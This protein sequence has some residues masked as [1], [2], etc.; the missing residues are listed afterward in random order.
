MTTPDAII[1]PIIHDP[2]TFPGSC[3]R[4]AVTDDGGVLCHY[5]IDEN[6]DI[7]RESA[8]GDGWH[9]IASDHF[10]N[11]DEPPECDHCHRTLGQQAY[12]RS[13]HNIADAMLTAARFV[14]APEEGLVSAM[15]WGMPAY[16]RALRDVTRFLGLLTLEHTYAMF[17]VMSREQIGHSLWLTRCHHGTGFWDMYDLPKDL[18]DALTNAAHAIGERWVYAT[19]ANKLDYTG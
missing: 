6:A 11:C 7:I 4:F 16:R 9:A 3:E 18:R 15:T 17:R 19:D 8:P 10:G 13:V 2:Y 14:D 1:T 5:C 12:P